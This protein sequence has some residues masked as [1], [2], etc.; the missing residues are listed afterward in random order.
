MLGNTKKNF[1]NLQKR[2]RNKIVEVKYYC[3]RC[4][5]EILDCSR[6]STITIE[7][8]SKVVPDKIGN[9]FIVPRQEFLFG[10]DKQSFMLCQECGRR[11]K[12]YWD[13][14]MKEK[15]LH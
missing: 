7:S 13:Q 6:Q 15:N 10:F 1:Q 2:V 3:D 8:E 9:K 11:F 5:K 4:K 12:K 14:Y